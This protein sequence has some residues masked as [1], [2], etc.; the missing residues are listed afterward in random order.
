MESDTLPGE[1]TFDL[2]F[3]ISMLR[4][5]LYLDKAQTLI[6]RFADTKEYF[7]KIFFSDRNSIFPK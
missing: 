3:C 4:K 2:T 5:E 1:V 7:M 6:H